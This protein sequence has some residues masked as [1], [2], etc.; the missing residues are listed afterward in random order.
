VVYTDEWAAYNGLTAAANTHH[1]VNHN[2]QQGRNHQEGMKL[3]FEFLRNSS[4]IPQEFFRM[5]LE[6]F[7]EEFLGLVSGF[8]DT[9][10]ISE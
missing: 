7:L 6:E 2:I 4:G 5:F 1:S 3:S 9:A 10:E 8:L